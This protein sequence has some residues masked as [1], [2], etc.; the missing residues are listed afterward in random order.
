MARLFVEQE[1]IAEEL[2]VL[3]DE[4]HKYLTR[5]LRLAVGDVVTLFD[6]KSVEATARITRVGPRALEVHIEERR[7]VAPSDRP[8]VTLIQGLAK[9]DKLDLVV[10]K[11]TELGVARFIPVTTE[12]AVA[13]LEAG[14]AQA[15]SRQLR[16]QKIAREAARQSG[17]L[18]IPEIEGVTTLQTAL[19]ASA[20]DALRVLLWEG[21]KQT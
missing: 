18:D 16:W 4:D 12:R 2:V 19:A 15:T 14:Q 11:S 10:Q 9:G 21:A 8:H 3:A 7:P 17:R 6:G 1:R 13:K 20:K 5:V